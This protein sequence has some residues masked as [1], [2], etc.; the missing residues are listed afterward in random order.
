VEGLCANIYMEREEV[1]AYFSGYKVQ[2]QSPTI[3]LG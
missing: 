1:E 2:E 3:F